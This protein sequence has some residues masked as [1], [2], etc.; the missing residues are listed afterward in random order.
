MC[1][2]EL[3]K[4][5]ILVTLNEIALKYMKWID[6]L[7]H[8]E[9]RS[10]KVSYARLYFWS[11]FLNRFSVWDER[12]RPSVE[13]ESLHFGGIDVSCKNSN[14]KFENESS[15]S[16]NIPRPTWRRLRWWWWRHCHA[17]QFWIKIIPR[18]YFARKTV[19]THPNS[20]PI[21]FLRKTHTVESL[22]FNYVHAKNRQFIQWCSTSHSGKASVFCCW[23]NFFPHWHQNALVY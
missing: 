9:T 4:L 7:R 11:K 14:E 13:S 18:F 21:Y 8:K 19:Q 15:S 17:M 23:S 20:L 22:P 5:P 12:P 16:R 2:R 3:S 10:K 6:L 1:H